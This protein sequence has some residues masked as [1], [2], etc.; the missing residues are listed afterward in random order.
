MKNDDDFI[1]CQVCGEK[2]NRVYGAHLKKHGLTSKEYK[3]KYPN[4][5]LTCNTDKKNTSKNSGLFMK[6]EKYKK[7]YSEMMKGEKNPNHK[8]KTTELERKQRSP[9]SKE[10]Y[11]NKNPLMTD[12]NIEME[13]KMFKERAIIDRGYTNR[14]DYY[15][16]K[17]FSE[18]E[19]EQKL[20]ERQT[21]FSK[22]TCISKYGEIEGLKKFKERQQKWQENLLLNGNLK[23][24][25]SEVSQELFYELLNYYDVDDRKSIYFALKNQEYFIS[26]K[27]GIFYQYDFT[28]RKN[29]KIIEYNGDEY[30]GNPKLYEANDNPHPFRKN[31]LASE[32]WKKDQDKKNV[33]EEEG[34]EVLIIWD[35]EY[36]KD[37]IGTINKCKNFLVL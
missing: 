12:N 37:K 24:G 16:K 10:F 30:H 26:L 7:K 17:G 23:C 9:F 18:E 2:V 22:E 28:D 19:A 33:A 29:K 13:V 27:G 25:F 1:I 35:S 34:F 6:E 3:E 36:K 5:P 8:N 4:S 20:K 15:I 21:T 31:I 11:I 32:M 14:L